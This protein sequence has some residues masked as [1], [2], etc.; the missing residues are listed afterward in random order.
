MVDPHQIFSGPALTAVGLA[1]A[2]AVESA[3]P[4]GLIADP[5][6][7]V[8]YEQAGVTLPMRLEWPKPGETLTDAERLH[9]HGS[10]YVGLRTRHYDDLLVRSAANGVRQGV[11]IGAGLDTRA[12]RL[13]L[14]SDFHLIELDQEPLLEWKQGVL[15]RQ[16]SGPCCRRSWAGTD[17]RE[18][19][20]A[21]LG[22]LGFHPERPAAFLAEGLLPY[23][24]S[25][26][27]RELLRRI[28]ALAFPGSTLALDRILGDPH[29]SGRLDRLSRRSG[30]DMSRLLAPGDSQGPVAELRQRG[31]T[32]EEISVAEL[33][34]SYA[35]DLGDPFPSGA[36]D[37]AREPPWLDTCFVHAT[38]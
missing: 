36:D 17:L 22:R 20:T 1:A 2:R 26:G 13:P 37:P 28:D 27:Q 30:L 16:A 5:L 7:R 4:D 32:V 24:S 29:S 11:L 34:R 15:D 38:R 8:L 3:R 12:F 9:L 21:R 35:R 31:W 14:P 10:R 25:E 33:A 6:A 23:L 19:W 18:D